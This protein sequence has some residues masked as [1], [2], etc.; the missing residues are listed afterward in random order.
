MDTFLRWFE[1]SLGLGGLILLFLIFVALIALI[2]KLKRRSVGGEGEIRLKVT[3]LNDY[4]DDLRDTLLENILEDKAWKEIEKKRKKEDS[5]KLKAEKVKEKENKKNAVEADTLSELPKVF[6]IDFDGDIQASAVNKLRDMVTALVA[7]ALPQDEIVLRLE[8]GGGMVHSYG[9]AAAQLNRLKDASLKLTICIDKIAASGGY[10]MACVAHR[11]VA[12]PFAIVGSIGVVASMPNLNRLLRKNDVDYLELT[13]GD[14]KRTLTLFGEV[15]E[16][17]KAKF[18]EQ[19]Q[20][21]HELFKNHIAHHRPQLD[22]ENV[23]TG[24]YWY[25][26]KAKELNLIDE[27][28]TSDTY[29]VAAASKS[30]VFKIEAFVK[31]TLRQKLSQAVM[32]FAEK[33]IES[34]VSGLTKRNSDIHQNVMH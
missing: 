31:E 24:E 14:Y 30:K 2:A 3:P 26:I 1:V 10:M 19:L 22:I 33:G 21:T 29:I 6:V 11:V 9:L 32:A 34:I 16:K 28:S 17:G 20:E 15:T 8:S 27:I 4:Y 13:A 23:G 7:V 5:E 25:G 18:Q 12:A